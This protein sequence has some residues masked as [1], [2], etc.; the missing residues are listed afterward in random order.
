MWH[1]HISIPH[2]SLLNSDYFFFL[3]SKIPEQPCKMNHNGFPLYIKAE[4][5]VY[6]SACDPGHCGEF[7]RIVNC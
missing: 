1:K 4:L 2:F 6:M 7:K 3:G 5:L